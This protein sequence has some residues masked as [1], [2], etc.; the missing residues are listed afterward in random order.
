MLRAALLTVLFIPLFVFSQNTTNSIKGIIVNQKLQP[1]PNTTIKIVIN[2]TD[3]VV[4]KFAFSNAEGKFLIEVPITTNKLYLQ[5]SFVGYTTFNLLINDSLINFT[6]QFIIT[7]LTKELP[8]VHVISKNSAITQRGDT[9]SFKV[10]AFAKGNEDN[11]AS[12]LK[13]LPGFHIDETGSINF[14]GKSISAVLVED[15]DL[16][17][18]GY[19]KLINN[20][21]VN[22]IETVEVIENYKDRS[23]LETSL[24]KGTQTVINL[25]YK[26]LGIKNFGEAKIGYA[27]TQNLY[28]VKLS[29]TT[30]SKRVKAIT[31]GNKN[32]IGFLAQQLYGLS[33]ETS[34]PYN[35]NIQYPARLDHITTPIGISNIQPLNINSNRLFDNNSSLVTT[36]LLIK[37][38]KKILFKNNYAFVNDYFLQNYNSTITYLNTVIPTIVTQQNS[39]NKNNRYFFSEGELSLNWSEK[40][41]TRLYFTIANGN[42]NHISNGFFQANPLRQN[43]ENK[44]RLANGMLTHIVI[45]NSTSYLNLKY[46]IQ[47]STSNSNFTFTNPLEDTIF[48]ISSASKQLV[49]H[50]AYNQKSHYIAA[51]WLKKLKHANI[52]VTYSSTFKNIVPINDAFFINDNASITQLPNNFLQQQQIN[53]N[54]NE[55]E[56]NAD[57]EVSKVFKIDLSTKFKH[58][59]YKHGLIN[60][61]DTD[62]KMVVLPHIAIQL[63]VSSGQSL[64]LNG[65]L[66]VELPRLDQLNRAMIFTG[67]NNISSGTN[68]V[69]IQ[70]GYEIGLYYRFFSPTNKK[71]ILN[72]FA[73]YSNRPNIYNNNFTGR[74][75]YAFNNL[76]PF[77]NNNVNSVYSQIEI[78]KNLVAF[79]SWLKLKVNPHYFQSFSNTNNILTTNKSLFI[80]S[81]L[82]FNT[83]WSKW[84]NINAAVA[85]ATDKSKSKIEGLFEN[86]FGSSEWLTNTTVEL[87]LHEKWF[88]DIQH[89]YLINQSF[90]QPVQQ[91][92]FL[93]AKFRYN[94]NKKWHT[95]LLLRNML[96]TDAF[97][98]NNSGFTKNIVQ[99]FTLTPFVA[100][101]SFGYK[102]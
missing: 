64:S 5:I 53:Y 43:I 25:K 86:N 30:L 100:L 60:N 19:N 35:N 45:L 50:V 82:R 32:Q 41:Q 69:N 65:G 80:K 47:T 101:F 40:Q 95:N 52:T 73:N 99:N 42:N 97:T 79:K 74:G 49:Q 84:F 57:K 83:S 17:G 24:N 87:K 37:P 8:E 22:G 6:K 20:A 68:T 38:S 2:D 23:K 85:Y 14:N 72:M 96:N 71:I 33:S 94:I 98:T 1:I 88:L 7:P 27:P 63:Q 3:G 12:L 102:F 78:E 56:I 76:T 59:K 54:E 93:D 61:L 48:K 51:S 31:L 67:I 26:K 9:T 62:D 58:I 29:N 81:E 89:D 21:S 18:R 44:N 90:N 34:L 15:D 39:I 13:K 91:I 70:N 92:Q 55:L 46:A 10:S 28:E 36:N 16:F 75:L 4:K 11:I 77:Y 66:N